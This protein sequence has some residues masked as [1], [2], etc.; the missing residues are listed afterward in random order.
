MK[1]VGLLGWICLKVIPPSRGGRFCRRTRRS[2]DSRG[3]F[4]V[5]VPEYV[6]SL[7]S[8]AKLYVYMNCC[9]RLAKDQL[10]SDEY[11]WMLQQNMTLRAMENVRSILFIIF[12]HAIALYFHV[13]IANLTYSVGGLWRAEVARSKQAGAL[14]ISPGPDYR[15]GE[16]QGGV[17]EDQERSHRAGVLLRLRQLLSLIRRKQMD[18]IQIAKGCRNN[19]S[20]VFVLECMQILLSLRTLSRKWFLLLCI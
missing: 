14:A 9:R 13:P 20:F 17:E 18:E 10:N 1:R 3:E 15:A 11:D 5:L 4:T 19:R 8:N 2:C 7:N 6:S 12:H 16:D